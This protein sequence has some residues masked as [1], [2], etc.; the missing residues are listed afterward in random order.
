MFCIHCGR[1]LEEGETCP[2]QQQ[3]IISEET[4]IEETE[5]EIEV[6][7]DEIEEEVRQETFVPPVFEVAPPVIKEPN[8]FSR[9]LSVLKHYITQPLSAI[10]Q[11]GEFGDKSVGL[12]CCIL[13]ALLIA[14]SL[15]SYLATRVQVSYSLGFFEQ[16]IP[17]GEYLKHSDLTMS[18]LF[19]QLTGTVVL[20]D[21]FLIVLFWILTGE[22]GKEKG[23]SKMIGGVG[24]GL[25]SCGFVGVIV[26][27]ISAMNPKL[28]VSL[29]FAGAVL[30]IIAVKEG[31]VSA[32]GKFSTKLFYFFPLTLLLWFAGVNWFISSSSALSWIF[33]LL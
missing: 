5:V 9:F 24:T 2:C 11:A 27:L 16:G 33:G 8:G 23:L 7:S 10:R 15:C 6:E 17:F 30:C 4:D 31:V 29:L 18:S 22:A 19:W 14:G 21:L 3:G 26:A 20:A 12:L 28:S 1:K 25:L 13:Q 32:T